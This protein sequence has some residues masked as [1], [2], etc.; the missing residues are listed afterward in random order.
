MK[1]YSTL[2]IIVKYDYVI[3]YSMYY[4]FFV[5]RITTFFCVSIGNHKLWVDDYLKKFLNR[6]V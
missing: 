4:P 5:S 2:L 3:K 1:G 6:V